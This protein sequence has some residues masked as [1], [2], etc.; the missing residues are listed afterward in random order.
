MFVSRL[1]TLLRYYVSSRK[2]T[3]FD[4]LISLL[5]ADHVKPMLP[6]DCLK[7]I[8]AVE[9]TETDGWLT[10]SKLAEVVDTYIA[11]HTSDINPH[12]D[13]AYTSTQ[14]AKAVNN[15]KVPIGKPQ[16]Q[17]KPERRCFE[18]DSRLHLL[19]H[20]PHRNSGNKFNKHFPTQQ[21]TNSSQHNTA[22]INSAVTVMPATS[23]SET[24]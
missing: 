18:C 13:V 8:L 11:S 4:N 12:T 6:P 9:N 15:D 1:S 5:I 14:S 20:C 10:H 19:K 17:S 7:H 16:Q 22:R 2:V 24:A 21:F 23:N 3:T